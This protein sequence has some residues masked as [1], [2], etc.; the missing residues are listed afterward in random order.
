MALTALVIGIFSRKLSTTLV[1]VAIRIMRK[2]KIKKL[3]DREKA[4]KESL[5]RYNGSAKYIR[6][7][8]NIIIKQFITALIQ[9]LAYYSVPACIYF[10]FGLGEENFIKLVA[11]QAIVY[12]TVSGIPSPGSVGVTEGAFISIYT[13][14]FTEKYISSAV[15]LNRGINFYLPVFVCGIVASINI[16]KAKKEMHE[17]G[18]TEEQIEEEINEE[19]KK[20]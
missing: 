7:N 11:L 18:I 9:Q 17:K 6:G 1:G 16:F 10:A 13:S 20:G 12:A 15:L 14:T 19:R 8:K 2:F 4:L 5:Y 3:K